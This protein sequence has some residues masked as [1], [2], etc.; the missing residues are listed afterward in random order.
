M[1][2]AYAAQEA[3]VVFCPHC[4]AAVGERA[5]RIQDTAE[6][7]ALVDTLCS[8]AEAAVRRNYCRPEMDLS[9]ACLLY[10]SR[11]V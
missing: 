3:A 8:L 5:A 9:G 1:S 4:G 10:T 11:C 6:K 2:G 7:L